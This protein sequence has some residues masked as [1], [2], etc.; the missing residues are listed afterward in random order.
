MCEREKEREI[1]VDESRH[2]SKRMRATCDFVAIEMNVEGYSKLAPEE[3][4][5][6][7]VHP[8]SVA[9]GRQLG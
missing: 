9:R 1:E 7:R 5:G 2:N 3:F 4:D 8:A 6:G